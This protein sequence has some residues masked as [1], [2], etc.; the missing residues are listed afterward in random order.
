MDITIGMLLYIQGGYKMIEALIKKIEESGN[1]IILEVRIKVPEK[2]I[3]PDQQDFA[4]E[5][6]F[7]NAG[8]MYQKRISE[9]KELLTDIELL[10]LGGIELIQYHK[11]GD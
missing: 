11:G 1:E 4:D 2:P 6:R 8:A 7:I 5:P 10:H 3:Q 9:W